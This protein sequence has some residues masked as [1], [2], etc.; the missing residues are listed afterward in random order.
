MPLYLGSLSKRFGRRVMY[1]VSVGLFTLFSGLAIAS[2]RIEAFIITRVLASF[3]GCAVTVLGGSVAGNWDV[4][5]RGL[6]MS[7]FYQ[8][9]YAGPALSHVIGGILVFCWDWPAVQWFAAVYGG[10]ILALIV[11]VLPETLPMTANTRAITITPETAG[12]E[13]NRN[14]LK[15][16]F[17]SYAS[18]RIYQAANI[19]ALAVIDPLRILTFFRFPIIAL[20]TCIASMSFAV[21]VSTATSLQNAFSQP[22][23]GFSTL[24]IGLFHLPMPLGLIPG[25]LIGGKWADMIMIRVEQ[26]DMASREANGAVAAPGQG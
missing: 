25:V 24:T 10:L 14:V 22:P 19:I 17:T 3:C 5:Q 4:D 15:L 18:Q 8:G 11:L 13:S 23:Y 7:F 9:L 12:T 1:I 21:L 16:R 6:A 20:T 2:Y 26:K